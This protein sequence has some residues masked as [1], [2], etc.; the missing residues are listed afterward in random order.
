[1]AVVDLLF[2]SDFSSSF[3][4]CRVV[5]VLKPSWLCDDPALT[6]KDLGLVAT[7]ISKRLAKRPSGGVSEKLF[8]VL[9]ICD[10]RMKFDETDPG[11]LALFFVGLA[12]SEQALRTFA[13]DT[14]AGQAVVVNVSAS[15]PCPQLLQPGSPGEKSVRQ[16]ALDVAVQLGQ[17]AAAPSA[18][19]PCIDVVFREDFHFSVC[20]GVLL[21]FPVV[22]F[23]ERCHSPQTCLAF[24]ELAQY[25][26]R[27]HEASPQDADGENA[28][29]LT[30]FTCPLALLQQ[31]RDV[32]TACEQW[33]LQMK[34]KIATVAPGEFV[35]SSHSVV[36]SAEL[37]L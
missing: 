13:L 18:P 5:L 2:T 30:S 6:S 4:L 16:W 28:L 10:S 12:A 24:Q 22:Y 14:R 8:S 33:E 17:Q 37:S 9:R 32:Q 31:Q 19:D 35:V 29:V 36:S 7:E 26:V 34:E 3:I 23:S 21:G 25:A 11:E 1:M 27:V 15:L 20:I